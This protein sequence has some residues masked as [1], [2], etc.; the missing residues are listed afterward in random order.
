M[1]IFSVFP[2]L[3]KEMGF[4][5]IALALLGST[6][7]WAYAF[8]SPFGGYLGDRFS[9]RQ[10]I[11]FSLL[12]FSLV[13][14]ATGLVR[15]SSQMIELRCLLGLSEAVFLPP[16]LAYI[17]SF[18]SDQTRSLANS[19][20]LTGLIAGAGLGSWYG[21]Y[22]TEHYSWRIGFFLLGAAGIIVALGA[23]LFLRK[24]PVLLPESKAS[25]FQGLGK[26]ALEILK[27]PTA[28]SLIFI[29]FALSLTSWPT[30]S[31]LPTYLFEN[32]KLS[33][34]HAGS[35]VS[36]Y[37][38][39]PALLGGITGGMLADRWTRYDVRGRM[40]VQVIGFSV[41]APTMLAIGY[42]RSSQG[43]AADLLI[44]SIARGMLECNSM[45]LFCSVVSPHRWSMA[46]GLYNLAGTLAG[47]LG[48]FFVGVQK[49]SWGIGYTLS[50]MSIL[51]FVALVVTGVTMVRY[52][53]PD[54]NRQR[55][56]EAEN[57]HVN[58]SSD[59]RYI[60]RS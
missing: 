55:Q 33:L 4:S 60:E 37:A 7:L 39:V 22:M 28:R 50:A 29:A 26:G 38:A 12:I 18:H 8:C 46:Y 42:M 5:D 58:S 16:A 49:G 19:I 15:N 52:L 41:M 20:A 47:S 32:F 44:Y 43:V 40:A 51:L 36:L 14:F 11:L 30:H 1:T 25:A 21:G 23:A 59:V 13:T 2:A 6:F 56:W 48:I 57:I 34:T 17:A 53:V 10:V 3:K 9:R 54:I 24:D 31:W 35:I 45:P 27:R